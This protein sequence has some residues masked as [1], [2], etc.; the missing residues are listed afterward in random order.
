MRT[1]GSCLNA[2]CAEPEGE[3]SSVILRLS[4]PVLER[5]SEVIEGN[6]EREDLLPG[7]ESLVREFIGQC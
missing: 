1:F 5:L 7:L 2:L 4:A 3:G 6:I